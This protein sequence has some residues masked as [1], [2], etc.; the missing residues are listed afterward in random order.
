[1]KYNSIGEQLIAKAKEID[2]NYKPDKFNDMSEALDVILNNSGGGGIP[3]VEGTLDEQESTENTKYYTIPEAQTSPFIFHSSDIGY[4][5]VDVDVQSDL[6][7]SVS[8][9]PYGKWRLIYGNDTSII[10]STYTPTSLYPIK[11]NGSIPRD[12]TS[13][14]DV[15]FPLMDRIGGSMCL[16]SDVDVSMVFLRS[17]RNIWGSFQTPITYCNDGKY[18]CWYMEPKEGVAI[19]DPTATIKCK[20]VNLDGGDTNI[21][22]LPADASTKNYT[23]NSVNGTLTWNNIGN[24]L[25]IKDGALQEKVLN[26]SITL[27]AEEL[28]QSINSG[29]VSIAYTG[30]D[31]STIYDF[32]KAQN[33]IMKLTIN[34]PIGALY[35]T[36]RSSLWKDDTNHSY[37]FEGTLYIETD[38]TTIGGTNF[39]QIIVRAIC[40][41]TDNSVVFRPTIIPIGK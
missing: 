6:Y 2:P 28:S 9:T 1:M 17:E 19:D 35:M 40:W 33:G 32:I 8:P 16:V 20:V 15:T 41:D 29:N 30:T 12:E 24:G 7:A 34:T 18:R 36:L 11:I 13:S 21:P 3:V 23:L 27:T 25:E 14:V 39:N 37:N 5:F 38:L 31:K 26:V 10:V 22:S 4:W